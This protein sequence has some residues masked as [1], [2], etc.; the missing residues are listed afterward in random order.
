MSETN[1]A[2]SNPFDDVEGL[3]EALKKA[4]QNKQGAFRVA[5]WCMVIQELI[6]LKKSIGET[7]DVAQ[8][9]VDGKPDFAA[10]REEIKNDLNQK[11][12]EDDAET[13][14]F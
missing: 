9:A 1:V 5:T 10:L 8:Q 2:R 14:L 7:A 4:P 3:L 12:S 6:H 11:L 13:I